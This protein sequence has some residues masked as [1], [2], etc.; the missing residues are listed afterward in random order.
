MTYRFDYVI[1]GG[2]AGAVGC[3]EA[4]RSVDQERSIALISEEP[5]PL[6]SRALLPYYLDTPVPREKLLYR[7]P[8]FYEKMR[9]T[10]FEGRRAVKLSPIDK[11]VELDD[12]ERLKYG[13][14]L[15]ATGGK[16]FVPSIEGLN[17]KNVFTFISMDDALG[18][19][20]ALPRTRNA[21]ILGGGVIGLMTAE[22]LR[23][24]GIGVSVVELAP[25]VLS[26]V[27]DETAGAIVEDLFRE[28]EV[29]IY[30]ATT[31]KKVVGEERAERVILSNG[32]DLP[33]DLLVVAVGVVPRVELARDAGIAVNRGILV[34]ERMET[35]AKDVYACG[36]CAEVYD[37]VIDDRRPLPLWT[38]AY[39]GGRT[40][41]F[42]MAGVAR[43]YRWATAMNA[44]H[45]FDLYIIS[46]GLNITQDL[47]DS[48]EVLTKYEP[49]S[50]IYRKFALKDGR[51][52]GLVLVGQIARAGIFLRLMRMQA[53]VAS[54]KEE[55]LKEAFGFTDIPEDLRWQ[56]LKEDVM[57]EVI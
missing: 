47:G 13:R 37:F 9:V 1:I 56:L 54:F 5:Y 43:K 31:I 40:A 39:A 15:L 30:T 4:L 48:F 51:I 21:V 28:Q 18:I 23:K 8:D 38:N 24:R 46:A 44:M 2:S 16:P 52:V 10:T 11:V 36:D 53:D 26:A 29:V 32:E 42:N 25:R 45:F 50:R 33:C 6:Y 49:Q 20:E 17:K 41:G 7:P 12:G 34:N 35:S 14:L 22:V 57:L 27:V 3:I 19:A 55:L